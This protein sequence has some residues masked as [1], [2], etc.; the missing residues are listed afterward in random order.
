MPLYVRY[1]VPCYAYIVIS[2][3]QGESPELL[4]FDKNVHVLHLARFFEFRSRAHVRLRHFVYGRFD[5]AITDSTVFYGR[6]YRSD[7]VL[8]RAQ[9]LF[10]N[11][12]PHRLPRTCTTRAML[13]RLAILSLVIY[14]LFLHYFVSL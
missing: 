11:K 10:L 7:I 6:T 8:Y 3:S 2:I 13:C 1:Y 9:H 4:K 12:K 14:V 5:L